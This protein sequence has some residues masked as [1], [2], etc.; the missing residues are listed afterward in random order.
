MICS[1][2]YCAVC[3]SAIVLLAGRVPAAPDVTQS[4]ELQSGWNSIYLEVQP[5]SNDTVS[6]F[7]ALPIS[8]AWTWIPRDGSAQFFDNLSESLHNDPHWMVF[9]PTNRHERMFNDLFRVFANRSY[10]IKLLGSNAVTWVVTGRPAVATAAWQ[11]NSYNLVGFPLKPAGPLPSLAAFL[12]PDP[13]LATQP[14]YRLNATG[15]WQ[16]VANKAAENVRAAE[17]LW[18]Y[19][20]GESDYLGLLHVSVTEGDGLDFGGSVPEKDVLL[21]N[22]SAGAA[23]V[24]VRNVQGAAGPVAYWTQNESTG[25]QIWTDLPDPLT[26]NLPAGSSYR[27][28]L[29][30]QRDEIAGGLYET[31]LEVESDTGTRVR[32]PLRAETTT[33]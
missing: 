30:I 24:T 8:S 12:A 14:V 21:E 25:E 33:P 7:G 9:F 10:F 5:A 16:V 28:R 13:N 20:G 6:V 32:I 11:P 26:L 22:R 3:V 27:L 18:V 4:I 2:T 17:S 1:R 29:A 19:A 15:H 23:V 31:T